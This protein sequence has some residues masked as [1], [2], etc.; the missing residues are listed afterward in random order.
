[1]K[2]PQFVTDADVVRW[3]EVISQDSDVAVIASNSVIREV[4]FAGLWLGEELEKLECPEDLIIRIQE[5]AGRLS[6]GRETWEVCQ[7]VLEDY[8]NN[9]LVFEKEPAELN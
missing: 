2:R 9:Q 7:K 4:C 1:M 6:F 5:A 8:K 3:T